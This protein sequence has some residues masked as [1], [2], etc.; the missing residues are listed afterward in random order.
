[1][2]ELSLIKI[3][4][5]ILSISFNPRISYKKEKKKK[6]I[7]NYLTFKKLISKFINRLI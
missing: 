3:L 2:G 7:L 5:V 4:T 6:I 1:M